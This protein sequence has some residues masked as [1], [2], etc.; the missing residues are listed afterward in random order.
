MFRLAFALAIVMLLWLQSLVDTTE[1]FTDGARHVFAYGWAAW[2]FFGG[3]MVI[4]VV[5]AGVAWRLLKDRILAGIILAG[6]LLTTLACLPQIWCERTEL[7]DTHLIHRREWPHTEFNADIPLANIASVIE[8]RR[9]SGSFATYYAVG[10]QIT[11]TDGRQFRLPSNTVLTA[12]HE[13]I[14]DV[15]DARNT[16]VK[17]ETIRR[18]PGP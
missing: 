8:T 16:P 17:T 2:L 11:M 3:F 12:A 4:F 14:N 7:T 18:N 10:Y 13:T 15:F 6:M 5:F 9:E 1:H